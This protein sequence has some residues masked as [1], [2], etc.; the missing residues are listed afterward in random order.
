M[1]VTARARTLALLGHLNGRR[2][3]TVLLFLREA[4][5]INSIPLCREGRLVAYPRLVGLKDADLKNAHLREARLISEN[6]REAVSLEGG[7]T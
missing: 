3:R 4:R 2:K 5:L 1:R 7:P 6:R